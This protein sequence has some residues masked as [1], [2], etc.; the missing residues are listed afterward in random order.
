MTDERSLIDPMPELGVVHHAELDQLYQSCMDANDLRDS[1]LIEQN[2][3]R[4]RSILDADRSI[5]PFYASVLPRLEGS[6]HFLREEFAQ[7]IA[8][9]EQAIAL[10]RE[11]G[12][13]EGEARSIM[14]IGNCCNHGGRFEE[15]VPPQMMGPTHH[16]VA[17]QC[18]RDAHFRPAGR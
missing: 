17:C 14:G 10:C 4:F 2:L 15:A 11:I 8:R 6:M 13:R 7:G 5:H 9:F 16:V 12:D 1:D 3:L 18:R